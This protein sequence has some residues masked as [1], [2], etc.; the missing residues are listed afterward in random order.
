MEAIRETLPVVV[1][2]FCR[3]QPPVALDSHLWLWTTAWTVAALLLRPSRIADHS[4]R[5]V[6]CCQAE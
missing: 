5:V 1:A 4:I 6:L 3:E 2:C